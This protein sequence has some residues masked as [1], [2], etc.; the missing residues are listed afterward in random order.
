MFFLKK[1]FITTPL[2]LF[3]RWLVDYVFDFKRVH[4][5]VTT[6]WYVCII[7]YYYVKYAWSNEIHNTRQHKAPRN[8]VSETENCFWKT[9]INKSSDDYLLA[10]AKDIFNDFCLLF[11]FTCY[12]TFR[13]QNNSKIVQL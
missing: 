6:I 12:V 3:F 13:D 2:T 7:I 5:S 1:E 8:K 10:A 4:F 11:S 9:K